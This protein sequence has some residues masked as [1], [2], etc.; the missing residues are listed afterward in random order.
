MPWGGGRTIRCGLTGRGSLLAESGSR[1]PSGRNDG[2]PCLPRASAFG[3]S[4][5]LR[6]PGPLGRTEPDVL[7]LPCSGELVQLFCDESLDSRLFEPRTASVEPSWN[8]PKLE[9]RFLPSRRPLSRPGRF[10]CHPNAHFSS[11]TLF[12]LPERPIF[13]ASRFLG[14]PSPRLSSGTGVLASGASSFFPSRHLRVRGRRDSFGAAVRLPESASF[15]RRPRPPNSL[16]IVR[17]KRPREDRQCGKNRQ[18]AHKILTR[19][20]RGRYHPAAVEGT[21][22]AL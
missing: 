6:S 18:S 2:G 17:V 7:G 15:F 4:P 16:C 12:E 3:L 9:N 21:R 14:V 22:R 20:G 13:F 8:L 1:A 11:P 5:G 19:A 10:F